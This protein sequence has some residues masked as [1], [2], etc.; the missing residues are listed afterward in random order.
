M[1]MFY[2][3]KGKEANLDVQFKGV[4]RIMH[5]LHFTYNKKTF[6]WDFMGLVS[7]RSRI[8]LRKIA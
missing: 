3:L 4:V 5:L 8:W 2:I 7:F 6:A 1:R